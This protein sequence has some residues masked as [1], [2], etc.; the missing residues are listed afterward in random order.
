[1]VWTRTWSGT[2]ESMVKMLVVG[3]S[4]S[5]RK[6]LQKWLE[7]VENDLRYVG[8]KRWRLKAFVR[9]EWSVIVREIKFCTELNVTARVAVRRW[10]VA[11]MTVE[12][13]TLHN[14]YV[15]VCV[16][17]RARAFFFSVVACMAF[18][19]RLPLCAT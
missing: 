17:V 10:T 15:C 1:M 5:C 13:I 14:V 16:C 7:D 11:R 18:C 12:F 2:H 9:Q 4:G 3:N 6:Y 8:V 19:L